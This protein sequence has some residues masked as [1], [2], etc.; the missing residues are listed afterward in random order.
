MGH[1]EGSSQGLRHHLPSQRLRGPS[2]KPPF[3]PSQ[4]TRPCEAKG[5]TPCGFRKTAG[6]P[7]EQGLGRA[8]DGGPSLCELCTLPRDSCRAGRRGRGVANSSGTDLGSGLA[9]RSLQAEKR[10][11]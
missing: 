9:G 6:R 5:A 4:Q 1:P 10:P 2:P 7:Q 3:L 11:R 8:G